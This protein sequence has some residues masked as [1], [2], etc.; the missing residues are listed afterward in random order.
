MNMI[1]MMNDKQ[2]SPLMGEHGKPLTDKIEKLRSI[3]LQKVAE[4]P[5]NFDDQIWAQINRE[6]ICQQIGVSQSTLGKMLRQ[7]P[8]IFDVK[9][10]LGVKATLVRVGL[11]GKNSPRTC[12]KILKVVWIGEI[13]KFN[14]QKAIIDKQTASLH[15]LDIIHYEGKLKSAVET[16]DLKLVTKVTMDLNAVKILRKKRLAKADSQVTFGETRRR[17]QFA[18]V[19]DCGARPPS[20]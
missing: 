20:N 8:F 18:R 17:L 12:A 2:V 19:A 9:M 3:I 5:F 13:Q 16:A 10:E 1:T 7:F 14:A 6:A 4:N 11:K 15:Q